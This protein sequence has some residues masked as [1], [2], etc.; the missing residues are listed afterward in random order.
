MDTYPDDDI[1]LN[2]DL[3]NH[4]PIDSDKENKKSSSPTNSKASLSA[5]DRSQSSPV[6]VL[7]ERQFVGSSE[8]SSQNKIFV[9]VPQKQTEILP[10]NCPG[11][12]LR[13]L[14]ADKLN[15]LAEKI[16]EQKRIIVPCK[17]VTTVK[18]G[19]L[20]EEKFKKLEKKLKGSTYNLTRSSD[21]ESED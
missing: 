13:V 17:K 5:V 12:K 6:S 19:V 16:R 15:K 9:R 8:L 10:K 3:F 11:L 20:S 18:A 1:F 14:S 21:E 7:R 2:D 4:V